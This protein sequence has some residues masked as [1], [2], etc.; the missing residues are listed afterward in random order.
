MTYKIGDIAL[1][2]ELGEDYQLALQEDVEF[3]YEHFRINP[4]KHDYDSII[5]LSDG[6]GI[7]EIWGFYGI[8]YKLS[9]AELLYK[10]GE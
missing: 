6:E 1:L 9:E 4:F 5:F 10:E 7:T 8:P 3:I 2:E